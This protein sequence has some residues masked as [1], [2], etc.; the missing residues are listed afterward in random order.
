MSLRARLLAG[1]A[2]VAVVLAIAAVGIVRTTRSYLLDQ[3]DTELLAAVE[4]P[5][6]LFGGGPSSYFVG[7]VR[8]DDSMGVARPPLR[9][10]SVPIVSYD[11]AGDAVAGPITVRS[12]DPDVR[13]RVVARPGPNGMFVVGLPLTNVDATV[14][15][16]IAVEVLATIAILGVLSLVTWWVIRL[17]VRPIKQMTGTASAIAAGDLSA[18]V[19][20]G[21]PGTEAGDLGVALN[22]MMGR[23]EDAFDERTRSENRLRQFV[24]D[25]SHE[26]RTPITTIRGYA[27][28][29]R[30][31]GLSDGTE[32][33]EAMRRTEQE[34]V[35]MGTLVDDLLLLARLDQGRPLD[36]QPVDLTE[37]AE[38]AVRDAR[39]VDP[40]RPISASTNGPVTVLGD[41]ARMRQVVANLLT[42]ALVH[43]PPG[44]PVAVRVD[45]AGDRAVLEVADE[46]P[47]MA[48]DIAARAFER[49]FR[50][51]PSRSRHAGGTGL[52][53]AIVQ[54]T[55]AAHGGVVAIDTAPGRGTRVRVE[56]PAAADSAAAA[57]TSA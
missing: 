50:A 26:L 27:E 30:A 6:R 51:D 47:G 44:T 5:R 9:T 35:R 56:I 29:Y 54:A 49:F 34:S 31:G 16:L 33:E 43:T 48:A 12:D 21:E 36:R 46:G 14:R 7:E 40:E 41:D 1:M 38:D 2:V 45:R 32:L 55:V 11:R 4:N 10:D 15:R 8:R 28:L 20:E 25:A 39:A 57:P 52:G 19:P 3:V 22:Q 53:L 13:Y 18:R 42:N 23:I 17:G 37:I 24:A